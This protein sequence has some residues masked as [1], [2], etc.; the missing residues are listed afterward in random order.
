MDLK[1]FHSNS[2]LSD[3]LSHK[4]DLI[5][6]GKLKLVDPAERKLADEERMAHKQAFLEK[7]MQRAHKRNKAYSPLV[8]AT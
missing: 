1:D 6:M 5:K 3:V 8:G 4:C 7:E 2:F